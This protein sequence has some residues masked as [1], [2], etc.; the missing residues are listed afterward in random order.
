MLCLPMPTLTHQYQCA[1]RACLRRILA[2]SVL[3]LI[4]CPLLAVD[5]L[6]FESAAQAERFRDLASEI[7][8]LV[9]QN[10]SLADSDAPLAQ[11]LRREV[12]EQMQAGRSDAEIRDYL[13]A[14]YSDF[15]LYRPRFSSVNLLIWF[16]PLL[17]VAAGMWLVIRQLRR[18]AEVDD[19]QPGGN[20]D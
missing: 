9:C 12:L 4:T 17:M 16:A 7:R 10:Q 11:D 1:L 20:L 19:S 15:V 18:P 3:L 2:V 8:C 13:V 5:V 14:R 6:E